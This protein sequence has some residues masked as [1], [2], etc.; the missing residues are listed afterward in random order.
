MVDAAKLQIESDIG[1]LVTVKE[2]ERQDKGSVSSS[3]YHFS[4]SGEVQTI[5]RT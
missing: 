2:Q 4:R 5:A 3:R 1:T